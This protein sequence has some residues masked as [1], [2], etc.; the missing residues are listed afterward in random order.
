[1]ASFLNKIN[2]MRNMR[3]HAANEYIYPNTTLYHE[4]VSGIAWTG[5]YT[6]QK[7]KR[8]DLQVD[9]LLSYVMTR[10]PKYKTYAWC[11]P[12]NGGVCIP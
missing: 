3:L 2:R 1:M 9:R 8:I 11:P 6:R 7:P 5:G 4:I 12:D 10:R